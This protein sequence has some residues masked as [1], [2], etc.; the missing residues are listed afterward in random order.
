MA[1]HSQRGLCNTL[2][3]TTLGPF[4]YGS[5]IT[6]F[7]DSSPLSFLVNN[8]PNSPKL[9]RWSLALSRWRA[10][11]ISIAGSSN[12]SDYLSRSIPKDAV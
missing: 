11:I 8:L 2:F 12:G 7:S 5:S 4:L 10:K 9:T 3:V 6:I 1:Y